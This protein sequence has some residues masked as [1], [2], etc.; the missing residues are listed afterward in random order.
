M[1]D[2][3]GLVVPKSSDPS[4]NLS[5]THDFGRIHGSAPTE[6]SSPITHHPLPITDYRFAKDSGEQLF[7]PTLGS[8]K[9]LIN[10]SLWTLHLSR[11]LS[12]ESSKDAAEQVYAASL[13]ENERQSALVAAEIV[14]NIKTR[15]SGTGRSQIHLPQIRPVPGQSRADT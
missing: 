6:D 4:H 11:T 3:W 2:A 1:S 8:L 14:E 15:E 13:D 9:A 5:P 12:D 7:A 10:T